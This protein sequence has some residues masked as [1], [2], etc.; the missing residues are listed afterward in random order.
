MS[1]ATTHQKTTFNP[2][3]RRLLALLPGGVA[4]AA[5]ESTEGAAILESVLGAAQ[6]YGGSS[7]TGGLSQADAVLGIKTALNNGVGSAITR[8]RRTNGFLGDNLIRV[9]LPGFLADTQQTLSRIGLS[10]MLDDLETQLNRGAER[11]APVAKDLFVDAIT[12][13]S[14]RDA[15]GIVNG[16]PTSATD[17]FK[18]TTTPRLTQL[19]RP[20][21][22]DALQDAG[23]IQ[24]FDR[25]AANV[26]NVPFAPQ[27]GADAKTSLI[28]HGIEK[29]LDGIFYYVGREEAAIRRDPVKRT[30]TAPP[31]ALRSHLGS[32]I[33]T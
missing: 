31:E 25:L 3:R 12:S 17:Y 30:S 18:R 14:V 32:L 22:T 10:G 19:V 23:A 27:L 24:T 33:P 4:L 15:I 7:S 26:Q 6:T 16:G 21:M 29:G 13:M 1:D 28:D 20:I 11:A 9:P 8:V 2:S 5:C